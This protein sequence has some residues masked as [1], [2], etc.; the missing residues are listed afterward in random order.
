[1]T[2]DRRAR[3][4]EPAGRTHRHH[5]FGFTDYVL[6][7][8][9]RTGEKAEPPPAAAW[10]SAAFTDADVVVV[11]DAVAWAWKGPRPPRQGPGRHT[12]GPVAAAR[13]RQRRASTSRPVPL[14]ARECI[15]A[16]RF[17]TPIIVPDRIGPASVHAR[18]SGGATFEILTELL[19]AVARL[20]VRPNGP[21]V[22]PTRRRYA[23]AGSAT[24][25]RSL[26]AV[27]RCCG[28]AR[29]VPPRRHSS[30]AG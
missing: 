28:R 4:G 3:P 7:L 27:V 16:L 26:L 19:T 9:D 5:G 21:S 12:H 15:E 1:M 18:E 10:V 8:S 30:M 20:P 14:I 24:R 11:E 2:T 17:G 23:D 25:R 22:A 29:P 6:V 13:P